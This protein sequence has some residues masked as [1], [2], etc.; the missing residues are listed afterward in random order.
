[1][2]LLDADGKPASLPSRRTP[3]QDGSLR[4]SPSV[5]QVVKILGSDPV[6][7][8]DVARAVCAIHPEYG[9]GGAH[10][11]LKVSAD[12]EKS[13]PVGTWLSEV[14]AVLVPPVREMHGRLLVASLA[15]VDFQFGVLLRN[16]GIL[17]SF[18][19][20]LR[21]APPLRPDVHEQW[22]KRYGGLPWPSPPAETRAPSEPPSAGEGADRDVYPSGRLLDW[23]SLHVDRH[24]TAPEMVAE[25][26]ALHPEYSVDPERFRTLAG[27]TAKTRPLREWLVAA[28][29]VFKPRVRWLQGRVFL[30]ALALLDEDVGR[31][32]ARAGLL[33]VLG[34]GLAE[35]PNRLALSEEFEQLWEAMA[36]TPWPGT[37]PH[38]PADEA[39][40]THT[41]DP[42][43]LDRLGRRPFAEVI[44]AR[45]DA[46]WKAR[47][48]ARERRGEAGAFMVHVHGPWGVGKSSIFNFLR[49]VLQGPERAAGE[50]WMVVDFNA[51]LH[52]RIRPPWWSLIREIYTQSAR[53][54]GW[55]RSLPLRARWWWWRFQADWLPALLAVVAITFFVLLVSGAVTV[56]PDAIEKTLTLVTGGLGAGALVYAFVRSLVLGSARAVQTYVDLK[57]DPLNPIIRLF[58]RLV[59]EI[60]RPVAVFVDD[61]DRCDGKYVV[62]LLEGIQTLFRT[63][64]VT[65]VIAADRKWIC[66][67]FE[68]HYEDF[69]ATIGE[70]GRPLGYLFLDKLFQVS[71]T[72]PRPPEAL[73][74]AYWK[75]LLR[76]AGSAD[77]KAVE[78]KERELERE[79]KA[80]LRGATTQEEMEKR[81]EAQPDAA[82]QQAARN[83]AAKLI[84]TPEAQRETE[85]RLQRFAALLEPN[86]RA[87]NRLVNAFGL[88]QAAH[89]IEGRTVP[90]E[91]LARW[92][93]VELRWPLLADYLAAHPETAAAIVER[94]AP[95]GTPE[96]LQRL[97]AGDPDVLRV[98]RG[99]A[100]EAPP[101]LDAAAIRRIV[102]DP[103]QTSESPAPKTI[104]A[105]VVQSIQ[106]PSSAASS[107]EPSSAG[108]S[109][110]A[111]P[112]AGP[113]APS[114][115]P[116]P[117]AAPATPSD[118]APPSA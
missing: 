40:P 118:P 67:S 73:Q 30:A 66:S 109:A 116:P 12:L 47:A 18:V 87:M 70:P 29:S 82:H 45:I 114:A 102:G 11:L 50:R 108:P 60:G 35:A 51:W 112:S 20:E 9:G 37:V 1:M 13:A 117:S 84:T 27:A 95:D 107:A 77:P 38:P 115:D 94:A 53:Q 34:L 5:R 75:G 15:A 105:G 42:A 91:A 76:A 16:S 17:H 110:A 39:V 3:Q 41:D 57:A 65:Y 79:V 68:K 93:I 106:P 113:A 71:A 24:F 32:M 52:Q 22:I 44:A 80:D 98:V 36:G 33:G 97:I 54:L 2:Q 48:A 43:C 59:R 101:V 103:A 83:V 99:D 89:L 63:A 78:A 8:L 31:E 19:E 85:H 96:P 56:L 90:P 62:E 55:W 74:S 86:P 72:V 23:V 26:L 104:P 92:T 46:V 61:L 88:H 25:L 69:G 21:D 7:A 58:E 64:P 4:L 28:G 111:S 81:I 100:G 14:Q 6:T 49:D 10:D